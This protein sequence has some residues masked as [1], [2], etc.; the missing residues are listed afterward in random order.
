[1]RGYQQWEIDSSKLVAQTGTK[2]SKYKVT[3]RKTQNYSSIHNRQ[4]E[5]QTHTDRQTNRQT[6]SH[7]IARANT[8]KKN[9][10]TRMPSNLRH[11]HPQMST[12]TR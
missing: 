6:C 10:Q 3:E 11:D 2:I 7:K 1:V 8:Y 12:L 9:K 4:M 5:R